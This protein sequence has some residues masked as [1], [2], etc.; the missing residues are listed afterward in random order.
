MSVC[1]ALSVWGHHPQTLKRIWGT[2]PSLGEVKYGM[3]PRLRISIS[4]TLGNKR[5]LSGRQHRI[6]ARFPR[7]RE[8]FADRGAGLAPVV[9]LHGSARG[10]SRL[11]RL[12]RVHAIRT[13]ITACS[14]IKAEGPQFVPGLPVYGAGWR[15]VSQA[16]DPRLRAGADRNTAMA[17]TPNQNEREA[18]LRSKTERSTGIGSGYSMGGNGAI[19]EKRERGRERQ[20]GRER[21]GERKRESA[22]GED[23]ARERE[24]GGARCRCPR[25]GRG[26]RGRRGGHY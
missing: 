3:I 21:E 9:R 20:S 14:P 8:A 17:R 23:R 6:R 1:A 11:A 7:G 22:R 18:K 5:Y 13:R 10:V 24:G 4:T 25:T 19:A 12:P 16:G 26:P 15:P 2:I